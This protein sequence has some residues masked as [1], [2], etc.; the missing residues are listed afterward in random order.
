[1]G[2]DLDAGVRSSTVSASSARRSFF[3][4]DLVKDLLW[5]VFISG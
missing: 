3:G 1:M 2:T 5:D 4:R